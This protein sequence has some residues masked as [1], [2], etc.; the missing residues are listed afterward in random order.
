M[1]VIKKNRNEKGIREEDFGSKPHSKGEHF[2][3]SIKAFFDSKEANNITTIAI[4]ITTV[5]RINVE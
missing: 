1:I 2:S 3:R 5:P 4:S